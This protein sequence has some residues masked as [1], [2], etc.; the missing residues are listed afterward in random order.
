MSGKPPE[1]NREPIMRA[2]SASPQEASR[3]PV[4]IAPKGE[5]IILELYFG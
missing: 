4:P 3:I 1:H 5:I 2:A